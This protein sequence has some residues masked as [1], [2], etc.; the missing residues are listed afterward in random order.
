[1]KYLIFGMAALLAGECALAQTTAPVTAPSEPAKKDAVTQPA[2]T[3][4]PAGAA[5]KKAQMA[6]KM[7]ARGG[8]TKTKTAS[9]DDGVKPSTMMTDDERTAHRKK[10]QSF[11]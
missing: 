9:A 11:K 3:T 2:P 1:M 10:L 7:E 5:K 8:A 4:A 6:R